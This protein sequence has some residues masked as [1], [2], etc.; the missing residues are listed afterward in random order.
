MNAVL[1]GGGLPILLPFVNNKNDITSLVEQFDGFLFTG[2]QDINPTLYG[3]ALNNCTD[4]ISPK[5]DE[6]EINLFKT[7]MTYNK[8][9]LG[10]CR[11]MQLI[12]VAL[13]GTLKQDIL[14]LKDTCIHLQHFQKTPYDIPVHEIEIKQNTLIH[15]ILQKNIICVN[16]VH[17]QAIEKLAK[18]LSITATSEDKLI[19][20]FEITDLDFGIA[21]QWHPE[22]L[23]NTDINSRKLFAAF[24]DAALK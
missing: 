13:G 8:P 20:A 9:V 18:G 4:E 5:R 19:E 21:V 2:G 7:I 14:G 6:F 11:G 16:S 3:Q 10:I 17:H 23:C 1:E 12:N 15:Q 22:R 24:I